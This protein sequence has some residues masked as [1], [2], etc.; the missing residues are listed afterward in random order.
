[1][2]AAAPEPQGV[3]ARR[4]GGLQNRVTIS[5]AIGGL[6]LVTVLSLVTYF[7]AQRYLLSQREKAAL[8]Q[9]FLDARFVRDELE[10]ARASEAEVLA[11]LVLSPGSEAAVAQPGRWTA[12]T[13]TLQPDDVPPD[14]RDLVASGTT[15]RQRVLFHGRPYLVLGV[16]LVDAGVDYFELRPFVELES[17]LEVI[18]NSLLVAAVVAT[19]AAGLLGRWSAGRAL[20]PLMSVSAAA[21]RMADGDL[22]T[23]LQREADPDLD[24]VARSFNSMAD[25]LETRVER[26]ARFVGDVTHELRSP[27][28]T[29]AAANDV[30][31]T[32]VDQVPEQARA[33]LELV[34]AEIDLLRDMVEE[35]LE[36]SRLQAGAEPLRLE[37]VY[38]GELALQVATRAGD[39]DF[40]V[41]LDRDLDAKPLLVDKRRVERIIT[42][43][44]D[45]AESHGQGVVALRVHRSEG[46]VRIAVEDAGP[47]VAEEDRGRI[48][49]RFARGSRSRRRGDDSGTGLGLA[50]V[51]EHVRIHGGSV[52]VEDAP[53]GTGARFVVDLPWVSA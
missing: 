38:L 23:R 52:W 6:V 19:V 8:R 13:E 41:D 53:G 51:A 28:T 15:A 16:P 46:V 30:L 39:S 34:V 35:L 31:R 11:A 10:V 24:R 36:L 2:T 44:I 9:A 42:N 49:E 3:A 18:R 45:N 32:R 27:L 22:H 7:L 37:P 12:S 4:I 21:G 40:V 25:A 14:L 33:A 48:F 17:T 1:V 50:L 29:L 5:F 43:L 20:R 26:D 47:G